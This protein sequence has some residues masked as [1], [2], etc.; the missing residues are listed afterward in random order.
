MNHRFLIRPMAPAD[1]DEVAAL[2]HR[3]TNEWYRKNLNRRIFGKNPSDC[4]IFPE[5]YE[6]LDP[7]CCL[8]A[9]DPATG[10]IHGSCFHHPRETHWSLGI[11]N[12]SPDENARGAAKALLH[13]IT[14]LADAAGLPLRL[15]SSAAN[16]DSF[17]LYSRAGFVPE[18]IY[19]DMFLTV[20]E[21]GMDPA[22]RPEETSRVRPATPD[23]VPAMA[24]LEEEI[25]GIRREKDFRFFLTNN[26]EIWSA[27]VAD[28]PGG[29]GLA[30]FM[31]SVAHPGSRMIGPG[32]ARDS[33]TALALIWSQLDSRHRGQTPVWLA[34][35]D[36][37][38]IVRTCYSWGARN[39][40]IH[41][42]QVRGHF[43]ARRGLAFPTFMPETG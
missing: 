20:P 2:I 36:A 30:G 12:A 24:A 3:S 17:S 39:C 16:M 43:P 38:E 4:R 35:C 13:E 22:S 21:N 28:L 23:D 6:A 32:V 40:E 7:G 8:L 15:V 5:V 33:G 37:P 19:Q 10:A 9:V 31:I 26:Q 14:R 1:W 29:E 25:S 41:L 42:A 27:L 34:P 18:R 11:M